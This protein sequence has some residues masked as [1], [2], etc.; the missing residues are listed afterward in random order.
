MESRARTLGEMFDDIRDIC[1]NGNTSIDE[2]MAKKEAFYSLRKTIEMDAGGMKLYVDRICEYVE[3]FQHLL[4]PLLTLFIEIME[5]D[6]YKRMKLT[7]SLEAPDLRR[8]LP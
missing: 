1:L 2:V 7:D 6:S 3:S 5:E 8:Y 4:D